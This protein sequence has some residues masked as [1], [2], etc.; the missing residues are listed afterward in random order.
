MIFKGV[1]P[2]S[3][4]FGESPGLKQELFILDSLMNDV[5]FFF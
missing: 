5:L 1:I 2:T 3:D 4:H